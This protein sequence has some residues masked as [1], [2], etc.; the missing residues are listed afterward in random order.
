VSPFESKNAPKKEGREEGEEEEGE[1]REREEG[2]EGREKRGEGA[3]REN[4]P[5]VLKR[6]EREVGVGG[7]LYIP[8]GAAQHEPLRLVD[9]QAFFSAV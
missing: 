9:L 3:G 8:R 5:G 1:G 4:P 6:R 7:S 2:R